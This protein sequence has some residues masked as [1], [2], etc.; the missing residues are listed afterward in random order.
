MLGKRHPVPIYNIYNLY[1]SYNSDSQPA[2]VYVVFRID[3]IYYIFLIF[4]F[5]VSDNKTNKKLYLSNS[6][7]INILAIFR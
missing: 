2:Q 5:N 3:C 4:F 7:F 1:T 6:G